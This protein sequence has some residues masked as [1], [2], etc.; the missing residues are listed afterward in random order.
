ME[1]HKGTTRTV[2]LIGNYAIKIARFWSE[3]NKRKWKTFLKGLLANIDEHYW[4]NLPHKKELLCPVLYKSPLGLILIMKR[5]HKLRQD[6]YNRIKF[7]EL[8]K[9]LPL[10]NQISNFGKLNNKI[11]LI[12]YANTFKS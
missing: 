8:Y 12:D 7:T 5:T 6:E 10:D 3:F 2:F 1:I 11:V 4:W 9:G